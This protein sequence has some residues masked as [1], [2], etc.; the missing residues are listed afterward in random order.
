VVEKV[1]VIKSC[2]D[3]HTQAKITDKNE[4]GGTGAHHWDLD[5]GCIAEQASAIHKFFFDLLFLYD[6]LASG[7]QIPPLIYILVMNSYLCN[8]RVG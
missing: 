8:A 4:F 6:C 2:P 1:A 5:E 3:K 7:R